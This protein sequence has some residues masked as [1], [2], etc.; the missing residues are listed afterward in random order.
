MPMGSERYVA[1]QNARRDNRSLYL[2]DLARG[3]LQEIGI[4]EAYD[5]LN[6][7]ERI[8]LGERIERGENAGDVLEEL[9]VRH[10][11]DL[12]ATE[13]H[14][15]ARTNRN[16]IPG[17]DDETE[18]AGAP[19]GGNRTAQARG[20]AEGTARARG[21][22]EE[23]QAVRDTGEAGE[24]IGA[25][26][27]GTQPQYALSGKSSLANEPRTPT[28][29]YHLAPDHYWQIHDE[30]S[31]NGAH[32][33]DRDAVDSVHDEAARFGSKLTSAPHSALVAIERNVNGS[34]T[35]YYEDQHGKLDSFPAT[36][37]RL[38]RTR[39][40]FWK[41]RIF[42][43]G[44]NPVLGNGAQTLRGI[45]GHEAFHS[46]QPIAPD[47]V[48]G[49]APLDVGQPL[50]VDVFL[51]LVNHGKSLGIM[52]R[53]AAEWARIIGDPLAHLYNK[54]KPMRE[55]YE[56]AY[57]GRRNYDHIMDSEH[58]AHLVQEYYHD[59]GRLAGPQSL[60]DFIAKYGPVLRIWKTFTLAATAMQR[61]GR[62]RHCRSPS[63]TPSRPITARIRPHR[64]GQKD[65][66]RTRAGN[67]PNSPCP[68]R[69]TLLSADPCGAISITS[70]S[71][72]KR[73]KPPKA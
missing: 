73:W 37:D 56:E 39:G 27:E 49:G 42:I 64:R 15:R 62:Q 1:E 45:M 50:P 7:S 8:E 24:G 9:A 69:M 26:G 16:Y 4:P 6:R 60:R 57:A 47:V 35:A 61:Q 59:R 38:A 17:F 23:G 63:N 3:H 11:N 48:K 31:R 51:R 41:G 32:L 5:T 29:V 28:E 13:P 21:N 71:T 30:L 46:V 43:N 54:T 12:P 10:Y 55:E 19:Q 36:L 20:A 67:S 33:L 65:R 22:P 34:L 72:H 70:A 68:V 58:A 14:V 44:F 40:F 66:L 52:E 2:D 18:T 53:S 25:S